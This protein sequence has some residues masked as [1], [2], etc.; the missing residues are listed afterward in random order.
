[1]I[2]R[3][4]SAN[5]SLVTS[6]TSGTVVAALV[7]TAA[8]LSNGY[9]A[10]RVD[11][12]DASVWVASG[13]RQAV[14]RA[15][16]EVR[17]F[18][19]VVETT[20]S[21][22]DL[23]QSGTRVLVIDDG[24]AKADVLDP[25]TA[26]VVETVPLPPGRPAVALAGDNVVVHEADT[27]RLWL[28]PFAQF[29]GFDPDSEPDL[30][31]GAGA[32][33]SVDPSGALFTFSP[34]VG[35]VSRVDASTASAVESATGVDLGSE[36]DEFQLTSVGGR[37]ALLNRTSGL[38]QLDGSRQDLAD[39]LP[40]G[41]AELQLPSSEPGEVLL[42]HSAG[43]ITVPFDG[44]EPEPLTEDPTG[45]PA[46]PVV[47]DGCAFA[48]WSS[49]A[50]WRSCGGSEGESLGLAGVSAGAQ[51][52]FRSNG[53]RAVLND[54]RGGA[55][56][57]V[58]SSGELIDNWEELIRQ[59]QTDEEAEEN[60]PENPPEVD[61]VQEPPV[62]VDDELG[63]RP[64]RTSVLPVLL[65]DYDSNGDVLVISDV[66]PIPADAGRVQVINDNQQLQISLTDDA[67]GS[68]AFDYTI[69][70]GRGGSATATVRVQVRTGDVNGPPRQVRQT[71]TV[72]ASGGVV[73]AAVLGDWVDPDGDPMYLAN[74]TVAEPDSASFEPGGKVVYTD[75]GAGAGSRTVALTVSDLRSSGN[76]RLTVTVSDSGDVPIVPD[77]F[78][79]VAYAGQ[80][81]RVDPLAH[82]RGGTGTLRLTSVPAKTGA[83]IT[84]SYE[85]GTFRFLSDEVRTHYLEYVVSDSERSA[86]G[87]VRV[88][89]LAPPETNLTPIPVPKTV[90]VRSLASETVQVADTDIDP[91]GGVLSVTGVE[92][93]PAN[94]AVRAE[95]LE[96]S[97][98]RVTLSAPLDEPFTFG[99]RVSNGLAEADGTIT[100]I[101]VPRPDRVQPPVARDD[102]VTVRVG[103]AIDIP[104]LAND[105][106]P[107]GEAIR[108][109]PQ[110]VSSVPDGGGLLFASGSRLRYLA[111]DRT[112]IYTAVYAIEGPAG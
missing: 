105:E 55:T 104:V 90:F 17:S 93:I 98:V 59:Q 70:D 85:K 80:E 60:D 62:A 64:S 50:L 26:E 31:L 57:A 72:V 109:L 40:D 96:Q 37:W 83:T 68:L 46:R 95:I 99:Y 77:P 11:L 76:G 30:S 91:A 52:T 9:T 49:G 12:N 87:L 36:G 97:A 7:A 103:D 18:D 81:V 82:V 92:E 71:H 25:A 5:R 65:N 35:T 10:Q 44:S 48:A 73:S 58:Q 23:V 51:L 19:T 108:L 88:E 111:P 94:A 15:N 69:S 8:V 41:P 42:A 16:T 4:I 33:V 22:L 75:A 2:G 39:V 102:A 32:L 43:L 14:A 53:L 56:W 13:T 54:S 61:K 27:G 89:V 86:T 38:L 21:D 107:D 101:E 100:V 6:V 3:W 63:A 24:G 78:V 28:V 106:H 67:D 79:V 112:G 47:V 66:E 29:P 84:P 110:L 1:V 45:S 20:G 34:S 74:A